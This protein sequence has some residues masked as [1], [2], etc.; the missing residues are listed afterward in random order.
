[1]WIALASE[2]VR[3]ASEKW[4][5]DTVLG[6]RDAGLVVALDVVMLEG[7]EREVAYVKRCGDEIYEVLDGLAQQSRYM[8]SALADDVL[9]LVLDR[10]PMVCMGSQVPRDVV[11]GWRSG[12]LG[13]FVVSVGREVWVP[14]GRVCSF[15]LPEL[16]DEDWCVPYA[17]A[18]SRHVDPVGSATV[19][20]VL[21]GHGEVFRSASMGAG[22]DVLKVQ[23]VERRG[24]SIGEVANTWMRYSQECRIAQYWS[25]S[26]TPTVIVFE[27]D[28][29]GF[30]VAKERLKERLPAS[31]AVVVC[32]DMDGV[33]RI[34]VRADLAREV[35]RAMGGV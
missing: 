25:R 29:A 4:R 6:A 30:N 19:R 15:A 9:R 18:L 17:G 31:E 24:R 33:G 20:R 5:I 11:E 27:G 28:V 23:L 35:V 14:W 32:S 13:Y 12:E 34:S 21:E 8:E 2:R 1:M 7:E 22:R 26:L 10:M 3:D 16:K